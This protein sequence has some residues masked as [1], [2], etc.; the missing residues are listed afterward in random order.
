MKPTRI[1]TRALAPA[2]VLFTAAL[3]YSQNV[4]AYTISTVAG[5]GTAGY[6]GD[7]SSASGAELAGVFGIFVDSSGNVFIA[8]QFNNRI[9]EI[10][11]GTINTVAGSGTAGYAG[12][13]KSPTASTAELNSPEYAIT[14]SSGNI[15]ISDTANFVVRKVSGGNIST[16]AG[17]NVKGYGGDGA[18]PAGAILSTPSG[19][20]FDSAGNLY[21]ADTGNSV[22]RKVTMSSNAIS[23]FI[24]DGTAEYSGDGGQARGAELNNPNGIAFDAAGNFYIADTDNHRIRKVTAST[25]VINTFAGIGTNTAFAGDGGPATKAELN[26]PKGVAVDAAGNVYIA[27]TFNNRIRMV[28]PNG[29]ITTIA[30]GRGAGYTG[31]GGLA[32]NALLNS[33]TWVAVGPN[34]TIYIADNQNNAI[35]LLTPPPANAPS[36]NAGGVVSA[37]AFG[38]FPAAAEGSWIEIYGANLASTSRSWNSGDF[39][40][41]SA[42]TSLSGT[43]VTIAGQPAF[44]AYVSPGQVNAQVPAGTG[45]GPQQVIVTTLAGSTPAVSLTINSTAPGLFAPPQLNIGGKQ[46]LGALFTDGST[47]VLPSAGVSGFTSRPAHAGDTIVVYGVGFGTVSPDT[48]PGQIAPGSTS[49]TSPVQ[50]FF[51]Q[52]PATLTYS[53]LAPGFVGLYQFNVVVPDIAASDAVPVTVSLGGVPGTQTLYTA[54]Q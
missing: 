45:I 49:T 29:I 18:T 41:S 4:P 6:T 52:T 25:G 19:L 28:T 46:Y 54:V 22:I 31:D 23:T 37:A 15:Y 27:D 44:V 14:D 21:I 16:F 32:T 50:F 43:S 36:I 48:P 24:G 2:A 53:G 8:D 7:G 40:G 26:H 1:L 39:N 33:P 38:A 35:R 5:N 10:T 20:A 42:P 30:G 9:R 13:G 11:N 34:G 17:T 12:D 47:Y 51:A 3:C